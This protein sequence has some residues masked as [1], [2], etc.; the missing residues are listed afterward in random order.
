MITTLSWRLTDDT[1]AAGLL[2][3][4]VEV[5]H[6]TAQGL[7]ERLAHAVAGRKRQPRPPVGS[8]VPPQSVSP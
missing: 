3:V 1:G 7:P 2:V 5:L 6:Q 4:L 8:P